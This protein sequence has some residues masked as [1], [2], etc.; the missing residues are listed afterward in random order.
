MSELCTNENCGCRRRRV[1]DDRELAIEVLRGVLLENA[2]ASVSL[3]RAYRADGFE[4][5]RYRV[6]A[7]ERRAC[8]AIALWALL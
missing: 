6:E 7:H 8:L 3:A 2:R 5:E 4:E 1:E